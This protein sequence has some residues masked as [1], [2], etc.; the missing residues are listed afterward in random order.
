MSILD[1]DQLNLNPKPNEILEGK[2]CKGSRRGLRNLNSSLE[3]TL[4]AHTLVIPGHQMCDVPY[5][6]YYDSEQL[7]KSTLRLQRL[8]LLL[9]L[10]LRTAW[11][12]NSIV[13]LIVLFNVFHE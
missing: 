12:C 8:N 2:C 1:N 13:L 3:V 7:R 4:G 10:V 11:K 5:V 9:Q 6:Y